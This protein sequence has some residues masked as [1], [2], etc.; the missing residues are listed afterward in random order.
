MMFP[1]VRQIG[2]IVKDV[3]EAIEYYTSKF[4][5]GPFNTIIAERKGGIIRGKRGDYKLK[6]AFAQLGPLQLELTE[7]LQGKPIQ[8]EFARD[9]GEGIH[10]LGIQ[11][12]DVDAEVE[13]WQERGFKVI[14]KSPSSLGYKF[15]FLDTDKTG[16]IVLELMQPAKEQR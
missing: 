15:A 8:A 12:D 4:G 10:H 14:Q 5:L 2:V 16:G 11:V 1:E 7:I 9:H 13:K 3:D 6:I